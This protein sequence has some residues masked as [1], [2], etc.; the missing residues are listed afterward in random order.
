MNPVT[1]TKLNKTADSSMPGPNV[2]GGPKD[3]SKEPKKGIE[4]KS[5]ETALG[6]N[7]YGPMTGK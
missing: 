2:K 3:P 6:L 7:N 5:P 4:S 1:P